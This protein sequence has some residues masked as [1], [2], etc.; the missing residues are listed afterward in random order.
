MSIP[1]RSSIAN[2]LGAHVGAVCDSQGVRHY[3]AADVAD[4]ARDDG[5]WRGGVRKSAALGLVSRLF[6]EVIGHPLR[7]SP[8]TTGATNATGS[9]ITADHAPPRSLPRLT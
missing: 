5:N 9:A 3:W 4:F 6:G 8:G 1:A 2:H 7:L